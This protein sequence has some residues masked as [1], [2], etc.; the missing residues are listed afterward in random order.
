[1]RN[2]KEDPCSD[3]HHRFKNLTV[4]IAYIESL[5]NVLLTFSLLLLLIIN[6]TI[7]MQILVAQ[8]IDLT[9]C[10]VHTNQADKRYGFDLTKL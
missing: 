7:A 4:R 6:K 10:Y 5:G 1:M 3:L 9:Y 8:S 2:R